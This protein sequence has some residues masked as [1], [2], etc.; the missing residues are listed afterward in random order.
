M[1]NEES[2]DAKESLQGRVASVLFLDGWM[3]EGGWGR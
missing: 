3:G 1:G 2:F